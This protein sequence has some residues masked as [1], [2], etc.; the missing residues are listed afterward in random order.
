MVIYFTVNPRLM[1]QLSLNYTAPQIVLAQVAT[2]D[3][4][5]SSGG[6]KNNRISGFEEI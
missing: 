4:D 3:S 1:P 6:S 5:V 2:M